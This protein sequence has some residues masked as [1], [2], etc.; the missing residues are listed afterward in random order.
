MPDRD[1]QDVARL[2]AELGQRLLLAGENPYRARAY[3]RAAESLF[4]LTLSL[5]DVIAQDRLREL[6]G[7]GDALA[8]V[9]SQL[10][11]DGTTPRLEQLRSEVPAGVLQLLQI[12]GIKPDKVLLLYRELGTESLDEAEAA[13]RVDRVAKAKGLG[14]SL[15]GRLLSGIELMR[16]SQGQLL[17]HHAEDLLTRVRANLSRSH[18]ELNRV[19]LAGDFRRGCELVSDLALI[20]EMREAES[21]RVLSTGHDV[22]LWV[23]DRDRYGLALVLATGSLGHVAGLQEVAADR[24][25]SLTRDGLFDGGERVP[26]QAEEDLYAALGLP[27]I[28]PELREGAGEIEAAQAGRVPTLV[29][30]TDIRGVLHNHTDFSD[31]GNTLE[32]M[33]AATRTLG[34]GYFG[35]ADHSQSAGYA[36][37]L[38]PERV[39]AQRELADA[40]NRRSRGRFRIFK[41]IESD[42]RE[43][44]SLD[45]PDEVL[46]GFDYVVASIHSRFKLIPARQTERMLR[47]V[48]NPHTTIL[49]H[50][51]GRL[52]LRREGYELDID[53]VLKA[54]AEHGVAV[55]INANPHRLDLDWRWYRRALEH[56][57]W[58][59]INP[60]AHSVDEL[61]LTRW[62]V[63]VARKGGVPKERVLNCLDRVELAAWFAKRK[64]RI[65]HPGERVNHEH[66]HSTATSSIS[67]P[68][69]VAASPARRPRTARARGE[70]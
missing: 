62:G 15:Q 44:G 56:G 19:E 52:L 26:C 25:L 18:P 4:T 28:P 59:S 55:E 38:K 2:L 37:G 9:I 61:T 22:K 27:L 39:Q 64:E 66:D 12:P 8:S 43:D 49:G 57:C 17:I 3:T 70:T 1:H 36:G 67:P 54:C 29:E 10:W 69:T 65:R 58:L 14:P 35:V 34:Y 21:I 53:A 41:G 30:G 20:A 51:T 68:A 50:L 60:D 16:R 23:A 45:Y 31:G 33:A 42:I 46:V 24:G 47:A 6:P 11:A 5:S 32:E 13:C 48:A 40:L 63:L 7:V